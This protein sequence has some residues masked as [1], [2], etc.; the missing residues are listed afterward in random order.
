LGAMPGDQCP[1]RSMSTQTPGKNQLIVPSCSHKGTPRGRRFAPL[2]AG[3][4]CKTVQRVRNFARPSAL[5]HPASGTAG[6]RT[7]TGVAAATCARTPTTSSTGSRGPSGLPSGPRTTPAVA[8]QAVAVHEPQVPLRGVFKP[9]IRGAAPPRP[10][11]GYRSGADVCASPR[12]VLAHCW[13][14]GRRR[15]PTVQRVPA[16]V[17]LSGRLGCISRPRQATIPRPG[18]RRRLHA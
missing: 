14:Q 15:R 4:V 16:A 2:G 8:R 18:P 5:L 9:S 10:G 3:Q 1:V 6:R 13:S 7:T 17:A 12:P 11:S